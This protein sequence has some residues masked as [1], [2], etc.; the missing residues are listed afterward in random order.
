MPLGNQVPV[1]EL[2]TFLLVVKNSSQCRNV[3]LGTH[4]SSDVLARG[5]AERSRSA[6]AQSLADPP[7][8]R[9]ALAMRKTKP[10][11]FDASCFFVL[12]EVAPDS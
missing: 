7:G 6:R 1:R 12:I 2:S 9:A 5:I 11:Y 3:Y 8:D 10:A 4:F